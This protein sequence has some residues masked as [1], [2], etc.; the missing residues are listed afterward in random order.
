MQTH[1][2]IQSYPV[3]TK[4]AAFFTNLNIKKLHSS[5]KYMSEKNKIFSAHYTTNLDKVIYV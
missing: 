1:H 3:N 5:K 4:S 2:T